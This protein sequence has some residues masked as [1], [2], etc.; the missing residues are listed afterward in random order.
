MRKQFTHP[1]S[2]YAAVIEPGGRNSAGRKSSPFP[3]LMVEE[4]QSPLLSQPEPANRRAALVP[5]V[6]RGQACCLPPPELLDVT[7]SPCSLGGDFCT[8]L[9]KCRV[10]SIWDIKPIGHRSTV[11][12]PLC[13]FLRQLYQGQS[14]APRLLVVFPDLPLT[15]W[16]LC[17]SL[18]HRNTNI[19]LL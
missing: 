2:H 3:L 8:G 15:H 10:I 12:N 16:F 18:Y 1:S 14:A 9:G 5:P 4:L 13:A 6:L 7:H 11:Q 19:Y 17:M